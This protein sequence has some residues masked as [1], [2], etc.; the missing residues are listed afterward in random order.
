MERILAF[1]V[2]LLVSLLSGSGGVFHPFTDFYE[3][4]KS[5]HRTWGLFEASFNLT[6]ISRV[7]FIRGFDLFCFVFESNW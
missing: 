6:K 4:N 5:C 7:D 3:L 1:V 2:I